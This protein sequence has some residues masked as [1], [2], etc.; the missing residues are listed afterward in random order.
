VR[1]VGDNA[2]HGYN[3]K[4]QETDPFHIVPLLKIAFQALC[5]YE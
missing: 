2:S 3:C 4:Q 5:D 1:H